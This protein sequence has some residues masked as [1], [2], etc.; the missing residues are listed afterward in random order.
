MNRITELAHKVAG[1]APAPEHLPRLSEL[2]RDPNANLEEVEGIIRRDPNL[3]ASILKWC[4]SAT[5]RG[6]EP[7]ETVEDAIMRMGFNAIVDLVM[8][9]VTQ[10]L[11]AL[12]AAAG[13]HLDGLWDHCLLTG[14]LTRKLAQH[15]EGM[16]GI[17]FTAGLLH[18]LGKVLITKAAP[19]QY[20][21][22]LEQAK[23]RHKASVDQEEE[24][25]GA[26][27]AGI[28]AEVLG[29][30]KLPGTVVN[31]IWFHHHP[32]LSATKHPIACCIELADS[33]AYAVGFGL[34]D[35]YTRHRETS[36]LLQELGL[37]SESIAEMLSEALAEFGEAKA[38]FGQD[39]RSGI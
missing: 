34:R 36:W 37:R 15:R 9:L 8:L 24:S 3:T 30:W 28:G 20:A 7:V 18:D 22:V 35:Q 2:L 19:Q 32:G 21:Q 10:D 5:Y 16:G 33:L 1:L 26:N 13:S 38:G 12:P 17:G 4:N 31:A 25:F 6:A 14:I 39:S 11:Y 23:Q 29:R 27:H